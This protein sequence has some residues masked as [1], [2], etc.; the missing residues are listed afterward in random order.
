MDNLKWIYASILNYGKCLI[1]TKVS[2]ADCEKVVP[3]IVGSIP[4]SGYY[5]FTSVLSVQIER[6]FLEGCASEVK[7][8]CKILKQ[9]LNYLSHTL[10]LRVIFLIK[11]LMI[12]AEVGVGVYF[13]GSSGGCSDGY[14]GGRSRQC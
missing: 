9:I 2:S 12:G 13:G 11:I 5:F 6:N 14:S 8:F 10:L 1:S 7:S 3:D 4:A